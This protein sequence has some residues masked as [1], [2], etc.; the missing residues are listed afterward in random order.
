MAYRVADVERYEIEEMDDAEIRLLVSALL[1]HLG[2]K[3]VRFSDS[4]DRTGFYQIKRTNEMMNLRVIAAATKTEPARE[5]AVV[6]SPMIGMTP[7]GWVVTVDPSTIPTLID[8]LN[9]YLTNP[10]SPRKRHDT[11]NVVT[12]PTR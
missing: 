1:D 11:D 2:L 4:E 3:A 8:Q 7:S 6:A 5:V 9:A 12:L 10:N